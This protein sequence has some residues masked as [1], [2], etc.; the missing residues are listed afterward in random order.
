V[1]GAVLTAV[2]AESTAEY[3]GRFRMRVMK[4]TFAAYGAIMTMSAGFT[5]LALMKSTAKSSAIISTFAH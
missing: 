2:V 3:S 4:S 1:G 5:S